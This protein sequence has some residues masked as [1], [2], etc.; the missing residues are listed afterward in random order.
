V[1]PPGGTLTFGRNVTVTPQ[2]TAAGDTVR[3]GASSN[4]YRVLTGAPERLIK[5]PGVVTV[6]EGLTT[7]P[8]CPPGSPPC[9][10]GPFDCSGA[11][12]LT[13]GRNGSLTEGPPSFAAVKFGQLVLHNG[14]DLILREGE[15]TFCSILMARNSSV[16][17]LGPSQSTI[18]VVGDVRIANGASFGPVSGAPTPNLNIEGSQLRIGARAFVQA[19]IK[20]PNATLSIGRAGV[21]KGNLCVKG[22]PARSDKGIM[23]MCPPP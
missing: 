23:L 10:V 1:N 20:A 16:T 13:L 9:P 19:F 21:I 18:N 12:D 8:L 22:A 15:Y 2:H 11:P 5:G 17:I 7:F 4:I 14:A 6:I 3:I